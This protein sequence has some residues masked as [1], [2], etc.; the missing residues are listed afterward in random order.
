MSSDSAK[1]FLGAMVGFLTTFI[2]WISYDNRSVVVRNRDLDGSQAVAWVVSDS[3][4]KTA[5]ADTFLVIPKNISKE[6]S[7][8]ADRAIKNGQLKIHVSAANYLG[9]LK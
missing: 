4:N 9:I 7:D 8:G 6:F 5:Q 2:Q 1:F 3:S